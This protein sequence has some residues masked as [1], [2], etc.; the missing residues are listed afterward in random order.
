MEPVTRYAPNGQVAIA[1]QVT[2]DG[3]VEV[4]ELN[5][6]TY[7]SIDDTGEEPHWER[8]ERRLAMFSR[9]V[10][11]DPRGIG[12]SDPLPAGSTPTLEERM[13]D[14]LAV[15]DAAGIERTA[16]IGPGFGAHVAVL[17][18]ATHPE[19]VQSLVLVN[20]SARFVRDDDYPIGH[21]IEL[22]TGWSDALQDTERTEAIPEELD[23]V[24]ILAHDAGGIV[25]GGRV[26]RVAAPARRRPG[27]C[28]ARSRPPMSGRCSPACRCRRSC[29]TG[30]MTCRSR[31]PRAGTWPTTSP[32]LA[33]SRSPGL[34]T[35]PTP[36]TSK[37]SLTASRSS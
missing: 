34:R 32:G 5:N 6:G 19:R 35:S 13:A 8:Y 25:P 21:P 36:A 33:S 4:L 27:P 37:S 16:V 20:G 28:R 18:A 29:C 1:F 30:A 11:Y 17:L 12:L 3:P 24:A 22:I 23:D 7:F 14:A 2:G 26:P 31:W 15:L 10:R 9:L